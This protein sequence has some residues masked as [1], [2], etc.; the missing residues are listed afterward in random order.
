MILSLHNVLKTGVWLTP[1]RVKIISFM[2][3]LMSLIGL[4]VLWLTGESWMTDRLGRPIGTDFSGVWHAGKMVLAGQAHAVFD[5]IPHF[6]F[7]RQN[8]N[9]FNIDVYGWHYPP[10]FLGIAAFLALFPYFPALL[11]WQAATFALFYAA[12]RRIAPSHVL[13][14]LLI[15]GF[16]AVFVTLG[17]GHNAFLTAGLLGFGLYF[18]QTRPWLAGFCIGLLAYKPQFGLILPLILLASGNFR[19]FAGATI[20][21]VVMTL[22]ATGIWGIEIWY[23]FLKGAEFTRLVVLEEGNTGWHKI[24]TLFSSI[25]LVSEELALSFY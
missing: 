14:P 10:F 6:E 25:P 13:T 17:H 4:S 24:Q 12:I 20:T 19:A 1:E 23:A 21:V 9:N 8:F 15:V 7:Q 5:P 16:P 2:M 3:I 11:I 22:V 18:R